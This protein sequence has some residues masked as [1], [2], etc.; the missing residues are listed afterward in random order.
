M[1]GG[2]CVGWCKYRLF[3]P[4]QKVLLDR[5]PEAL[6]TSRIPLSP[7]KH[8]SSALRSCNWLGQD[9]SDYSRQSPSL[10][11]S[12]IGKLIT[13]IKKKNL[14]NTSISAWW[15]H[16]GIQLNQMKNWPPRSLI[17]QFCV[18]QEGALLSEPDLSRWGLL[19]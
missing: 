4:S 15:N 3:P 13:S 14:S 12:L 16:Q 5:H 8:L 17:D 18:I 1:A 10:T 11:L 2:S 6:S 9:R 7:Q 19:S